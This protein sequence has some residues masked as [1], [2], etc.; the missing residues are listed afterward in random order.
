V[1][2]H[3]RFQPTLEEC[4]EALDFL[5]DEDSYP[6][7]E[8]RTVQLLRGRVFDYPEGSGDYFLL[9]TWFG[10]EKPSTARIPVPPKWRLDDEW[11]FCEIEYVGQKMEVWQVGLIF[12]GA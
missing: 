8:E 11:F 12:K 10:P 1:A 3:R 4:A 9:L 6:F 5:E 2:R 7:G